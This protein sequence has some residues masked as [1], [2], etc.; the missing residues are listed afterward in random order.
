MEIVGRMNGTAVPM[1]PSSGKNG[2]AC[3]EKQGTRGTVVRTLIS[4]VDLVDLVTQS[5]GG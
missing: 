3:N 1:K 4:C 5:K 2:G